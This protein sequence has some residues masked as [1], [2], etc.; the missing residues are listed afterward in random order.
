MGVEWIRGAQAQ[1]VIANV[2]HFA[3]N[4]QEGASAPGGA[5]WPAVALQGRRARRR[6][7]AASR[8]TCRSS[9]PRSR[10]GSAGSVM[11]SYNRLNG[12]HACEN[13]RLLTDV[14]R[15]RLGLQAASCWPTTAPPSTWA[16]ACAPGSTSSRSRTSTSTAAR[17]TRRRRCRRR[18]RPAAPPRR[19]STAPSRNLLRT[20]FAY[21]FFDRAA[22]ADDESRID[23][24]GARAARRVAWPRRASCCCRT[25]AARCRSTRRG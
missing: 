5:S 20:L 7:H 12:P 4:N 2:K 17:S 8:S 1:G 6:A 3:V 9:R 25:T 14:L 23:R 15:K 18:S 11:C 22:Y 24:T 13:R 16:A 21:G 10:K 19:R